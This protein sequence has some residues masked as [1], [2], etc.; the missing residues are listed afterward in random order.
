MLTGPVVEGRVVAVLGLADYLECPRGLVALLAPGAVPVPLGLRPADGLPPRLAVGDPVRVG[1]RQVW[2]RSAGGGP[3]DDWQGWRVARWWRSAVRPR[4]GRPTGAALDGLRQHLPPLPQEMT[5]ALSHGV[6][7]TVGL[8]EGLT[9][10]GDDVLAGLLVAWAAWPDQAAGRRPGLAAAVTAALPRT[11]PLSAE[12]LRLAVAGH[13]ATPM[14]AALDAVA[15]GDGRRI[16]SAATDLLA[17]GHSS[18]AGLMHGLL[19]GSGACVP[20]LRGAA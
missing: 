3:H 20:R 9:P 19:W 6:A 2:V 4:R 16:D 10:L 15:S 8:G 12:L 1:D 5:A 17:V 14:L 13:A 11:T 18:G 7:A